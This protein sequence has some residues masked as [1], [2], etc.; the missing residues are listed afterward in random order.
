[1]TS[2]RH[3]RE[4]I[5][6]TD[7]QLAGWTG[8]RSRTELLLSGACPACHDS[9]FM[10]LP[11][12]S[13]SL[14]SAP[15]LP[16]P[17]TLTASVPCA[18]RGEHPDRPEGVADG[19]GRTWT[20]TA[21]FVSDTQVDVAAA[22]DPY[23]SEAAEALRSETAGRLQSVRTAADRWTAAVVTLI[24][25]VGIVLPALGRDDIRSLEPW[26]QVLVGGSLLAALAA[27]AVAVVNG[28]SAAHGLPVTRAVADDEGLREWYVAHRARASV[29]GARLRRAIIAAAVTIAALAAAV[30]VT[31]FAPAAPPE[32]TPVQVTRPDGAT[33]CGVLLPSTADN[34]LRIRRADSGDIE[35]LR[36]SDL[37]RLKPVKVC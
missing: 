23:L 31:T 28:H 15:G 5:T 29:A 22:N 36:P 19:C 14:E 1:M 18:C 8:T 21:T 11:L 2:M 25:L 7:Q 17:T 9:M 26:A 3:A 16:A 13:T 10:N 4:R 27:A 12:T 37:V 34:T 6:V 33:V 20:V 30:G 35:I 32:S 24:G